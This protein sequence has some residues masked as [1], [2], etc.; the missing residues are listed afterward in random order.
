MIVSKKALGTFM[1]VVSFTGIILFSRNW[2]SL[3]FAS[4]TPVV[5]YTTH[6][7]LFQFK[8]SAG[9]MA[10]KEVCVVDCGSRDQG[11]ELFRSPPVLLL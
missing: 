4:S 11:T 5:T 7:V 2:A 3:V 1:L 6:V 10:V 8:E 9:S